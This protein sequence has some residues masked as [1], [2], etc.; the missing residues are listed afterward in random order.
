MSETSKPNK[1]KKLMPLILFVLIFFASQNWWRVQLLVNPLPTESITAQD[2]VLYST[3]WC[4]YCRKAR[5]FLQRANMPFIEYDIEKSAYAYQQYERLSGRGV[6]VIRIGSRT[7]QGYDTQAMREAI[8][9][10]N[11]SRTPAAKDSPP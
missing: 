3:A 5:V 2:I 1:L 11:R 7:V 10:L 4:P 6:P 8:T 9:E